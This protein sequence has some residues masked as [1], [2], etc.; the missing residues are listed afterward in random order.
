MNTVPPPGCISLLYFR[1]EHLK[2]CGVNAFHSGI[3]TSED[4]KSYSCRL[5]A[6]S[7]IAGICILIM[8]VFTIRRAVI[9]SASLPEG[10]FCLLYRLNEN[11]IIQ[12]Q[13]DPSHPDQNCCTAHG[14]VSIFYS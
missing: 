9:S 5:K 14:Y 7:Q 1:Q 12:L 11:H 2:Q 3:S 6:P 10:V 4:S 8:S 13:P